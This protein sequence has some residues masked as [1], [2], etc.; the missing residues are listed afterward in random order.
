MRRRFVTL[1]LAGLLG[2]AIAQPAEATTTVN[3]V[4]YSFSPTPVTVPIGSTVAWHNTT[5]STTHTSTQDV[6]VW[7]TGNIN[8]GATKSETISW[9]GTYPYHCTFH[10]SLGMVG[11]VKVPIQV[12]PPSGDASTTFTITYASG[13]MPSGFTATVQKRVGTGKWTRYQSGLTSMTT[14]FQTSTPGTYSFR[15]FL[16]SSGGKTKPS[17]K[18][19]ITVN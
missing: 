3:A 13:A 9:A 18:K 19:K 17:P 7:D 5:A 10:A 8:G 14:T 16:V 4:N 2:L 6:G 11:T 1:G 15:S 12:S